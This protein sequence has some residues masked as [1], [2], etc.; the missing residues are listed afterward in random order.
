MKTTSPKSGLFPS[1]LVVALLSCCATLILS[2]CSKKA[3][4]DIIGK[5]RS[6]ETKEIVEFRK[7]G[8]LINPQ[9]EKQ[10]GKYTF[11]DGSHMN[12]HLNNGNTNQ[13]EISVTSEVHIHGD[14][15]EMIITDSGSGIQSHA[16]FQRLK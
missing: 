7:D 5:W 10:N 15:M 16:T 12:L 13:P 14:K 2:S 9:D 4:D 8:T 11:T 3:S 1:W 6:Q